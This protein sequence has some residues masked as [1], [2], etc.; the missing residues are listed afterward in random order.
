[1]GKAA[2]RRGKRG[3]RPRL[4]GVPR[5]PNGKPSR[6]VIHVGQRREMNEQEA[7]KVG[8]E[9]RMR[10]TGLP[11]ELAG[12]NHVGMPNAGTPHG[13][14]YLRGRIDL[15]EWHAAEWWLGRRIAFLRA[16]QAPGRPNEP[17]GEEEPEVSDD[18]EADYADWVTVTLARWAQVSECIRD[19]TT[20]RRSPVAAA[21]DNVLVRGQLL[22][23]ML[24]DL[25][26]A[27][28]AISRDFPDSRPPGG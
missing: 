16:V 6:R 25:R 11:V 5:E 2:K 9:A 14:L 27:L 15:R 20:E 12:L 4:E 23:H 28:D 26:A 19:V 10:H 7:K 21:L 3:G 13:V 18:P 1:M 24:P 17:K 8:V 22:D